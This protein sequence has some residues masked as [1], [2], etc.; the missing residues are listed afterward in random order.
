MP[1]R[2]SASV[3][4]AAVLVAGVRAA[5][6]PLKPI[7]ERSGRW[8]QQFEQD[9]ITVIADET[10]DQFV[11]RAKMPGRVHRRIQSEMLFMRGGEAAD[12]WVSA[13]NVRSYTDEGGETIEIPNSRDRLR[14]AIESDRSGG[15]TAVRRLADESARFNIGGI[16]RNFNTPTLALQFLD[17]GHRK[18]FKFRLMG[19]ETIGGDSAWRLAY[20]ERSH[21]TIIKANELDTDL[22]GLIWTR[23]SDGAVL[24]T[25]MELIA[26]PRGFYS[27]IKTIVTVE[28]GLDGKL[29]TMVPVRMDEQYLEREGG[30]QR[31][32]GTAVYSNYRVF[33]TSGRLVTP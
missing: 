32:E 14:D 20:E 27:G 24:R 21:P 6:D 23:R 19:S 2:A 30:D 11:S 9:F 17:D 3:A 13:R 5:D 18:R 7:V 22:A 8:V 31:I 4:L 25:R 33:E 10:Y 1:G 26:A 15:H 29:R 12:S 16:G 28:Y